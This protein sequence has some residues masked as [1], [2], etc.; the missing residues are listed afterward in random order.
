FAAVERCFLELATSTTL[1]TSQLINLFLKSRGRTVNG[2][3]Y[4]NLYANYFKEHMQIELARIGKEAQA[5]GGT[6]SKYYFISCATVRTQCYDKFKEAYPD[7]YQDIL[8]MHEEA[9]LLGSSPQTIAQRGHGF[10]KHYRRVIQILESAA[11]K[12][13]FEAAIVLCG[14]VVNEDGSLGHSYNTPGAAGFWE[15][16]CRASDDAIVGHLKAHVYNTTSLAA[17]DEAFND[18]TRNDPSTPNSTLN[19]DRD[20]S[21]APEGRDDGLKW[22]KLELIRQVAQLGG[23]CAWDKNFP[24]K[25][26]SSALADANLCIRGYP[27]HKCLL[28]GE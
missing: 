18:G 21:Q 8:L 2:T 1:P 9:S 16:R 23:K 19:H 13:G 28:P 17:V 24:W 26:M 4:W 11:M 14:K 5:G 27:A 7:S 15:T 20:Q 22:I 25:G 6:P 10:Q 3:N 12:S